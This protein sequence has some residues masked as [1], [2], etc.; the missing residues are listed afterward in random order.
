MVLFSAA[1]RAAY[2]DW[3]T[4]LDKAPASWASSID[5]SITRDQ[6]RGALR[7]ARVFSQYKDEDTGYSIFRFQVD[8]QQLEAHPISFRVERGYATLSIT[9]R[10]QVYEA[11][12]DENAYP[13]YPYS[14]HRFVRPLVLDIAHELG[15][16][17]A[18]QKVDW[19]VIKLDFPII[20][21]SQRPASASGR[22]R[23]EVKH[24]DAREK[25]LLVSTAGVV[26]ECQFSGKG[27]ESF[28]DPMRVFESYED[29]HSDLLKAVTAYGND[30]S[31]PL[32]TK[33]VHKAV[34]L[35]KPFADAIKAVASDRAGRASDQGG[36]GLTIVWDD[37]IRRALGL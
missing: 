19:I 4:L 26:A 30:F 7:K 5:D 23:T 27:I 21:T 3:L 10:G 17:I 36:R 33:G 29:Y 24:D 25:M 14:R 13:R 34:G 37:E 20:D 6:L 2:N 11:E 28:K 9:A 22:S 18:A 8:A 32:F 15:H 35:L 1:E 12:R 31:V 16:A